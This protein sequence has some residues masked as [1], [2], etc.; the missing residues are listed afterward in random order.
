MN[1]K[2]LTKTFIKI[3]NRKNSS[4]SMLYT[5]ILQL[6]KRKPIHLLSGWF[7]RGK[8]RFPLRAIC[9]PMLEKCPQHFN[10]LYNGKKTGSGC[11]N[12]REYIADSNNPV[13]DLMWTSKLYNLQCRAGIFAQ[14]TI[15]KLN[16][17]PKIYRNLCENT[18]P[19]K[20]RREKY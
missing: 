3:S 18:E 2:E 7:Y 6:C 13:V 5:Q 16:P 4:I 14:V 19:S 17:K 10:D 20:Q 8:Q 11:A 12:S 15:S 9:I 1:R